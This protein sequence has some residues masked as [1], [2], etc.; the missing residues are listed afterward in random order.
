MNERRMKRMKARVTG[1]GKKRVT[2]MTAMGSRT[3]QCGLNSPESEPEE[4]KMQ[5]YTNAK[6]QIIR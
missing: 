6:Y 3:P 5:N 1:T 4:S 2:V